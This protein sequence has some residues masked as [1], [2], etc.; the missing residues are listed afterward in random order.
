MHTLPLLLF[1]G[2]FV[3]VYGRTA[4]QKGGQP[5]LKVSIFAEE[6]AH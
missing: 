4:A 5:A 3:L 6:E 2:T 1:E